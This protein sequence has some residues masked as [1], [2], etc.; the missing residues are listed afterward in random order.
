MFMS[1]GTL[2]LQDI[3]IFKIFIKIEYWIIFRNILLQGADITV[4]ELH[5]FVHVHA[6]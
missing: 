2:N 1:H 3:G 6:H 5:H 4:Q